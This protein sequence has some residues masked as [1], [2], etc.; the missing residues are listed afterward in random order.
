MG[1]AADTNRA[2]WLTTYSSPPEVTTLPVPQPGPGSAVIRVLST[3]VPPYTKFIHDGSLKVFNLHLPLVPNPSNI[4]YIHAVGP[5]AVKLKAGD[6]VYYNPWIKARDDPDINII[7]GHHGG[8]GPGGAKLMQGEWRDGSMQQYQKVPLEKVFKLNEPRLC[9]VLGYKAAELQEFALQTMVVGAL[10][11]AARLQAGETIVIGP[12]TG[13]FGPASVEL[14][15]LLGANV[16]A[17]GRSESKL[18]ELR[19]QLGDPNRLQVV[20]MTGDEEVDSDAILAATPNGQGAE[21]FNDWTSG[22]L[23]TPPFFTAAFKTLKSEGRIILSGA[24]S[25]NVTFPYAYAMHKNLRII[26]KI[27]V[28]REGIESTI[29]MVESGFLKMGRMAG[30]KTAFFP[31]DQHHEAVEYAL[32]HG[33]YKN[34]TFVTPND[35]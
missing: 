1:E 32:K 4:G 24:P 6:L 28:E 2:I 7:Q 35:Q 34:Y 20:V 9:G 19:Q 33:G 5:D 25:G 26:G 21:V 23:K 17:L 8:E 29:R 14:A 15:L 3:W 31:L 12:A 10:C 27:M 18:E 11:E 22:G 30:A 13:T 16:I